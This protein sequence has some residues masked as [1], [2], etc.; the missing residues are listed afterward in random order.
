MDTPAPASKDIWVLKGTEVE[1]QLQVEVIFHISLTVYH[2]RAK[3]KDK[4]IP[5][6]PPQSWLDAIDIAIR[7]MFLHYFVLLD[8]SLSR[9]DTRSAGKMVRRTAP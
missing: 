4:F 8:V 2:G 6:M 3:I 7:Y 1:T 5:Y 9:P